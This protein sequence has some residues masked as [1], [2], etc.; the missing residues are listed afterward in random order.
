MF[1]VFSF[2]EKD[3]QFEWKVTDNQNM[4]LGIA[5]KILMVHFITDVSAYDFCIFYCFLV[6]DYLI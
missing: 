3:L 6:E 1:L 5:G 4:S 2:L